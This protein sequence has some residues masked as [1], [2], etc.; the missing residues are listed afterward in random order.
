MRPRRRSGR[1]EGGKGAARE[2]ER[3][4]L[5]PVAGDESAGTPQTAAKPAKRRYSPN[6]E[7][8]KAITAI[9]AMDLRRK[10]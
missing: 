8:L 6:P 7:V 4:R 9:L 5:L 2:A 1:G 3:L 10:P